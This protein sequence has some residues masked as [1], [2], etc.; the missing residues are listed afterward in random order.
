MAPPTWNHRF[1]N[2]AAEL[3]KA[4]LEEAEQLYPPVSPPEPP[5]AP[6]VPP[7]SRGRSFLG[8]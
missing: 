2:T 1:R 3:R 8:R 6:P 7:R 4:K 5:P